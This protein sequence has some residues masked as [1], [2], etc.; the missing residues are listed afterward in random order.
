VPVGQEPTAGQN[1]VT[2]DYFQDD[3]I[4]LTRGRDFTDRDDLH[5]LRCRDHQRNH[6]AH[7]LA[8]DDPIGKHIK[9]PDFK[10]A[11]TVVGVVGD[12]KHGRPHRNLGPAGCD[13]CIMGQLIAAH[14]QQPGRPAP[15]LSMWD[16]PVLAVSNHADD[17]ERFLEV[18]RFDVL[19]DRSSLAKS[20]APCSV[21]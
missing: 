21:E 8:G 10:E 4:P 20:C 5:A 1:I 11:L 12:S 7:D 9:T 2:P 3:A 6:G 13:S 19:A 15:G 18:R 16:R 14:N 17:G